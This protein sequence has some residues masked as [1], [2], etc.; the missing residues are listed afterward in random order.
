[1]LQTS[2]NLVLRVAARFLRAREFSSPK[3]RQEY[4]R[5]HPGADPALHTVRKPDQAVPKQEESESKK[6][7]EEP[8]KGQKLT[9]KER[10]KSLSQKAK[11]FLSGAPPAIQK[12]VQDDAHRRTVLMGMHRSLLN[13]PAKSYQNVRHAVKHEIKE[14]KTA[15][16]GIR[17]VLR[18][19]KMSG[20]QKTA[21]KLVAFDAAVTV[22]L[23]AISGGLAA[24]L[25]GAATKGIEVFSHSLA[26]KVALNAVT[27][28]LG[29]VVAVE[30]LGHFGHG[31]FG[32]LHHLTAAEKPEVD[33]RDL[34]TAYITKI[35]AD[36]TKDL[37]PEVLAQAL[38][39][40]AA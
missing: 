21:V 36:Q 10:L 34:I 35:V 24:G 11:S 18:G 39:E 14:F 16:E 6:G 38:E 32:L 13:L 1:M 31:L 2:P 29:N 27:K 15:G 19:E 17:G 8:T 37:D 7:P 23:V 9:F 20:E 4:L 12:F 40:A 5:E 3:T 22:A 30:E 28:G 26:K 33:D 25:T